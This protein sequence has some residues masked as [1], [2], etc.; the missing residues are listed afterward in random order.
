MKRH[1]HTH[2]KVHQTRKVD[3][4]VLYSLID[5][6]VNHRMHTDEMPRE[7]SQEYFVAVNE[8]TSLKRSHE[9]GLREE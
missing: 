3:S 1:I 7:S 5:S 6:Y 4:K 9:E 8:W 2:L